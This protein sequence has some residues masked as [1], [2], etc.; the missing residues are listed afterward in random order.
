MLFYSFL[1]DI[2][3]MYLFSSLCLSMQSV[4]FS[5]SLAMKMRLSLAASLGLGQIMFLA[6]I[7]ATQDKE[8]ACSVFCFCF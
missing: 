5:L 7:N 4:F 6:G 3:N 2:N 8:N 1:L